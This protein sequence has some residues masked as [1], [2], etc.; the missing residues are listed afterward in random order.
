MTEIKVLDL[1]KQ[2]YGDYR[3]YYLIGTV[4]AISKAGTLTVNFG[5]DTK[6]FRKGKYGYSCS[7][8]T[9]YE[10]EVREWQRQ[11]PKTDLVKFEKPWGNDD[12]DKIS[13]T[14][15]LNDENLENLADELDAVRKWW[16]AKPKEK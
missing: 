8:L 3:R 16:A 15:S 14:A 12:Y 1:V 13:V 10:I 11:R 4:T 5:D 7:K 9:E 6:Q 2:G